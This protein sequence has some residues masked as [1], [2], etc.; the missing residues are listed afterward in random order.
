MEYFNGKVIIMTSKSPS[1]GEIMNLTDGYLDALQHYEEMPLKMR[2]SA[3]QSSL[4]MPF[5]KAL[6]DRVGLHQIPFEKFSQR[7]IDC[8]HTSQ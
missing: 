1:S 2:N 8:I 6:D 4:P 7:G 3:L 5:R